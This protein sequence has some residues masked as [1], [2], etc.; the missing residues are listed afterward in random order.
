MKIQPITTYSINKNCK[1]KTYTKK[2]E[3]ITQP[4][5]KGIKG[6]L[7]G[8]A[9]GAGLTASGVTLIAG[10]GALPIF[11]GYIALNGAIGAVSG[12]LAQNQYKTKG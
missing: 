5:F 12:H 11:L 7:T 3:P 9:I 6:F 2:E 4:S 1:P 8:G 10:V